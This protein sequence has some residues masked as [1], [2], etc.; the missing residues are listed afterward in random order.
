MLC[1]ELLLMTTGSLDALLSAAGVADG[2]GGAVG[3]GVDAGAAGAG[4]GVAGAAC[5]AFG[6]DCCDLR[7]IS[8][9]VAVE[10]VEDAAI[11]ATSC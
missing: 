1:D 9:I 3:T 10:S 6:V 5:G 8:L 7:F 4:S 2:G 11:A